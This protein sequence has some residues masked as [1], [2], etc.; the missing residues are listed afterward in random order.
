MSVESIV[1]GVGCLGVLAASLWELAREERLDPSRPAPRTEARRCP[2]CHGDFAEDRVAVRCVRCGT[3]HHGDCW[4]EHARCSVHG[5]GGERANSRFVRK[6]EALDA[7]P[8]A[9]GTPRAKGPTRPALS[10]SGAGEVEAVEI[11]PRVEP[12]SVG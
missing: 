10:D 6:D 2:Y 12:A 1:F 11:A 8:T 4:E 5:C 7:P 3:A 9:V